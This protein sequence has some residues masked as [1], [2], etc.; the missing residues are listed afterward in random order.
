MHLRCGR[1]ISHKTCFPVL[2]SRTHVG[3]KIAHF[4]WCFFTG[5]SANG[6]FYDD[7]I[8]ARLVNKLLHSRYQQRRP[9]TNIKRLSNYIWA[10]CY[11][12]VIVAPGSHF[13][14][15]LTVPLCT[16]FT[17]PQGPQMTT[18]NHLPVLMCSFSTKLENQKWTD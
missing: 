13:S 4:V 2:R 11:A 17:K 15:P 5:L 18:R 9:Q 1:D 7:G 8:A 6:H 10:K 16:C 14:W 3:P 12:V